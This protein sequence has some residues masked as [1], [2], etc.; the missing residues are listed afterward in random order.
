M[1]FDEAGALKKYEN[2][3]AILKDFY[4]IRLKK[5]Y[6]RKDYLKGKLEAEA[7]KLENQAR[8]ILEKIE[9]QIS[10]GKCL[11]NDF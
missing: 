10:I 5:Y 2:V 1:L 11:I 7:S 6:E 8:F 4:E 3:D 9:G